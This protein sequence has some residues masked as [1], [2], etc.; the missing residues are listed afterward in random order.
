MITVKSQLTKKEKNTVLITL[1]EF[2]DLYGDFY[3]TKDNL[4]LFIKENPDVLIECLKKGD[5]IAFDEQHGIALIIGYSDNAS[6]KY[7]KLLA[8]DVQTSEKLIKVLQQA[9]TEDL[10][11]KIKKNNPIKKALENNNFH[12][13]GDRGKEILLKWSK[14]RRKDKGER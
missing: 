12:F 10:Y 7:I 5:I 13:V 8:K 6:R 14:F 9:V 11:A 4:R 3:I 1:Q 2:S